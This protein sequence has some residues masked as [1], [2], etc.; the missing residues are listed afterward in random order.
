MGKRKSSIMNTTEEDRIELLKLALE[1]IK[2]NGNS[3][4][5]PKAVIETA[6]EL[7]SY[8]EGESAVGTMALKPE[9][10][11]NYQEPVA[12]INPNPTPQS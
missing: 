12:M 9:L 4:L 3:V 8:V 6:K 7:E 11:P 1:L 2:Y 5:S 10:N